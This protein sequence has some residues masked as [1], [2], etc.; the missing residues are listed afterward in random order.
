MESWRR[1]PGAFAIRR[2]GGGVAGA[3]PGCSGPPGWDGSRRTAKR[4]GRSRTLVAPGFRY[5]CR[6]VPDGRLGCY[7]LPEDGL[8]RGGWRIG[9]LCAGEPLAD[10]GISPASSASR[11]ASSPMNTGIHAATLWAHVRTGRAGI[12]A[13]TVREAASSRRGSSRPGGSMA[14]PGFRNLPLVARLQQ[15]GGLLRPQPESCYGPWP[16]AR[17]GSRLG[18]GAGHGAGRHGSFAP[19]G[20]PGDCAGVAVVAR[21]RPTAS[22]RPLGLGAVG[23]FSIR[24]PV[25]LGHAWFGVLAPEDEIS[26]DLGGVQYEH[27]IVRCCVGVSVGHRAGVWQGLAGLGTLQAEQVEGST[28]FW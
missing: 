13:G 22:A 9:R 6:R 11:W 27:G 4:R 23:V 7:E 12:V 26:F 3:A 8:G 2:P 18:H 28:G 25:G 5:P 19:A 21:S 14:T 24:L 10:A 20:Q 17:L 1:W 15:L 16:D